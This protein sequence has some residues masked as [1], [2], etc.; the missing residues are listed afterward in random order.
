MFC[1]WNDEGKYFLGMRVGH[2]RVNIIHNKFCVIPSLLFT[3]AIINLNDRIITIYTDGSCHT[4]L[5]TGAWAAIILID[6]D[7]IVLKEVV[8]DTTHNRMEL[9]AVIKAIEYLQDLHVEFKRIDIFT[10]SQYVANL[11]DRKMKLEDKNYLTTKGNLIQNMDLVQMLIRYIET[12]PL[13]FIKVAAHLQRT[14]IINEN[15]EVDKIVRSLMRE[16]IPKR[17]KL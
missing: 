3:F 14:N 12:L 2:K 15:R 8:Q 11:R 9:L 4:Q 10:D 5:K 1:L 6:S 7:R 17:N 16:S 13:N